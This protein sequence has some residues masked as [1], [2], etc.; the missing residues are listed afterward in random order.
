M[1]GSKAMGDFK[2]ELRVRLADLAS[3]PDVA[4]RTDG[5]LAEAERQH[6]LRSRRH[7]LAG[8]AAASAAVVGAG[9]VWRA[10]ETDPEDRDRLEAGSTPAAASSDFEW[11][12]IDAVDLSQRKRP[13]VVWAGDR[14]IVWGGAYDG[15]NPSDGAAWDP[16]TRAWTPIA[17]APAGGIVGGFAVWTGTEMI[18]GLTESDSGAPWFDNGDEERPAVGISSYDPSTDSWRYVTWMRPGAGDEAALHRQAV[19]LDDVLVVALRAARPGAALADD[20]VI[21]EP[22]SGDR[23]P[24][25]PGPFGASPYSDGSGEVT[26]TAVGH[27]VVATPNWDRR[28]WILDLAAETWRQAPAPDGHSLHLMPA[29][30]AG[31]VVI[32]LE[33]DGRQPLWILDP[34]DR[35]PSPWTPGPP[36]P[37]PPALWGHDPLWTGTELYVPGAAFN[38]HSGAW[39]PVDGPPRG[40][41]RQRNLVSLVGDGTL[42]LFGGEEYSCPD[43]AECD[44]NPGPDTLDGWITRI[45]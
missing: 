2:Q 11:Q 39:R 9:A 42:I 18:V 8:A 25:D 5:L 36:N 26:L 15:R 19:A 6:H 34:S 17:S 29:T 22:A 20:I 23:H 13:G 41:D 1:T 38:P 27:R 21:I 10:V 45:P 4:G 7:F 3:V 14:L 12:P 30:A 44:R 37:H 43:N 35:G 32:F 33:S 31:D 24:I 28:P 16:S 40:Q